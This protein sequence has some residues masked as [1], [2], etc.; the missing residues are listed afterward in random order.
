MEGDVASV[1]AGT[2]GACHDALAELNGQPPLGVIAFDCIA[3]RAVLGDQGISVEVDRIE[4]H[5][6]AVP[7]AGFYT[8]GEIARTHGTGGFHNQT[9]VVLAVA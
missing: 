2:D 7:L 8:Y 6:G 5:T 1:L 9:L 4:E 3:R